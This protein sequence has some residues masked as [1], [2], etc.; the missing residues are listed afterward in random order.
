[1]SC[2]INKQRPDDNEHYEFSASY[3]D[4][5]QLRGDR[6]YYSIINEYSYEELRHRMDPKNIGDFVN[7]LS[8][9]I[10]HENVT[11]LIIDNLDKVRGFYYC[12]CCN[13]KL[14]AVQAIVTCLDGPFKI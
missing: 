14:T 9:H 6:P 13:F 1:M 8:I 5:V 12:F 11:A 10:I 4:I 7:D 3:Q 2:S